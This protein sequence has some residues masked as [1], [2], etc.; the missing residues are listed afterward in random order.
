MKMSTLAGFG[1]AAAVGGV[2]LPAA[3]QTMVGTMI[4]ASAGSARFYTEIP[5]FEKLYGKVRIWGPTQTGCFNQ[6]VNNHLWTIPVT[7]LTFPKN[8]N[9]NTTTHTAMAYGVSATQDIGSAQVT[10]CIFIRVNSSGEVPT[11]TPLGW[12]A[13]SNIQGGGTNLGSLTHSATEP[14]MVDCA[15]FSGS[16]GGQLNGF[17]GSVYIEGMGTLL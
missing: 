11:L 16:N 9:P 13:L 10:A 1:L 17:V 3:S 14:L 2:A 6:H 7:P 5:C 12:E 4:P 8:V 15:I